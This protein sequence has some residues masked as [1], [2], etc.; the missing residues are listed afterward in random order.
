MALFVLSEK[1]RKRY[2]SEHDQLGQISDRRSIIEGVDSFDRGSHI[3]HLE[4]DAVIGAALQYALVTLVERKNS[5]AVVSKVNR[6]SSDHVS[7]AFVM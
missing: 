5:Y 1:R 6:K 2:A 4:G 3:G 7:A